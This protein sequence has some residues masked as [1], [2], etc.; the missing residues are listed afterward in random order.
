MGLDGLE[1][2][3]EEDAGVAEVF[4]FCADGGE[5][6]VYLGLVGHSFFF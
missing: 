5:G 1:L 6:A 3:G 2:G 4:E